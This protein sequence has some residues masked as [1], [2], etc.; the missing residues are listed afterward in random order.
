[1]A[2]QAGFFFFFSDFCDIEILASIKFC[3]LLPLY[4]G[5]DSL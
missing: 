2:I 4:Y 1:M 5:R 3:Y